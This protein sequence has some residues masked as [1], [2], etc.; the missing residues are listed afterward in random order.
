ML[1]V[2]EAEGAAAG[3]CVDASWEDGEQD[4]RLFALEFA[5]GAGVALQ[6]FAE[7]CCK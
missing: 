4:V 6:N 3:Y 7:V 2:V 1:D 5:D